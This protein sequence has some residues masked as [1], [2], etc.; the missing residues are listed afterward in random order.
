[1]ITSIASFAF[2]K[3]ADAVNEITK[4]EDKVTNFATKTFQKTNIKNAASKTYNFI[5][6]NKFSTTLSAIS[7]AISAVVFINISAISAVLFLGSISFAMAFIHTRR[8]VKSSD[9]QFKKLANDFVLAIEDICKNFKN[10]KPLK[11]DLTISNIWNN[12]FY[13]QR[14]LEDFILN[15]CKDF[16]QFQAWQNYINSLGENLLLFTKS[17]P[18]FIKW[19]AMIQKLNLNNYA[20]ISFAKYVHEL[21]EQILNNEKVWFK[22]ELIN[23]T[24]DLDL[25]SDALLQNILNEIK[26]IDGS[27]LTYPDKKEIALNIYNEMLN[28]NTS[29]KNYKLWEFIKNHFP[30]N[31]L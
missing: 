4:I 15:N 26:N 27:F 12:L 5:K 18:R 22:N 25:K 17:L 23:L 30:F 8:Y 28:R 29:N 1:M 21:F 19:D 9:Y 11:E 7:L 3:F 10:G 14:D 2:H 31:K 6:E 16:N 24:K 20:S 13:K